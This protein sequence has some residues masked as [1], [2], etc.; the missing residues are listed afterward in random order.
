MQTLKGAESSPQEEHWALMQIFVVAKWWNYLRVRHVM[1]L[2]RKRLCPID[3]HWERDVLNS[4]DN[5]F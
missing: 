3:L 5:F 1:P 2:G 4:A